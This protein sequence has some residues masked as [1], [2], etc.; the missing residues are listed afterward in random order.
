MLFFISL[1]ESLGNSCSLK[2]EIVW[3]R[4][5]SHSSWRFL[6]RFHPVEDS[7]TG[8]ARS[9]S[10]RHFSWSLFFWDYCFLCI[11]MLINCVM[12]V[13]SPWVSHCVKQ[14]WQYFWIYFI[15][16]EQQEKDHLLAIG[17]TVER[18]LLDR[19]NLLDI[20]G[21]ILERRT[22]HVPIVRKSSCVQTIWQNMQRDTPSLTLKYLWWGETMLPMD[23]FQLFKTPKVTEETFRN[24]YS[25]RNNRT[26]GQTII[27]SS[28]RDVLNPSI[29]MSVYL[30]E[31]YTLPYLIFYTIRAIDSKTD[32]NSNVCINLDNI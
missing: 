11:A 23:Q 27:S 18:D 15:F 9:D 20:T 28:S 30:M 16:R 14:Y 25:S 17:S 19:M 26:S 29:F 7:E 6:W 13:L 21:L 10:F 1:K 22:S 2:H 32:K 4:K 31:S 12:A 8:L 24:N 5:K 3:G